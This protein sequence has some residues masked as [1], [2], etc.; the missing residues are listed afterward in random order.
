MVS[1]RLKA[2]HSPY[3][4]KWKQAQRDEVD[5]LKVSELVSVGA[6]I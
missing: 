4:H 6:K 5:Q 3:L 2:R 1:F